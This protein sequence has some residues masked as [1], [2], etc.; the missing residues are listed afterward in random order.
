MMQ[1]HDLIV[2]RWCRNKINPRLGIKERIG[3]LWRPVLHALV[4]EISFPHSHRRRGQRAS[5][6]QKGCTK[7]QHWAGTSQNDAG[8]L[9]F[10]D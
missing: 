5:T 10:G 4:G 1:P 2:P 7:E 6:I 8:H 3:C 9:G